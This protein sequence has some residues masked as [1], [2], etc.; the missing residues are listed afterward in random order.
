MN[1]VIWVLGP[2]SYF[3]SNLSLEVRK[4]SID[5]KIWDQKAEIRNFSGKLLFFWLGTHEAHL[6]MISQKKAYFQMMGVCVVRYQNSHI[7]HKRRSLPRLC[8]LKRKLWQHTSRLAYAVS[9]STDMPNIGRCKQ[10]LK[11]SKS[12][13]D[14]RIVAKWVMWVSE[15]AKWV[16][17]VHRFQKSIF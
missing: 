17:W 15:G 3:Y 9:T 7:W 10:N 11:F 12:S 14:S 5:L 6:L 4:N 1:A 16:S 2:R 13:K 8:S